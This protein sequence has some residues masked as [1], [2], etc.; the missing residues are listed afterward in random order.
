MATASAG[1][2]DKGSSQGSHAFRAPLQRARLAVSG[3]GRGEERPKARQPSSCAQKAR[4][5]H[6]RPR[7]RRL[8]Q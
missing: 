8:A 6:D 5:D 4:S 1:R 3:Q 2:A 7:N